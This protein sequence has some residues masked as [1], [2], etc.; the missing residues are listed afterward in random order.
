VA[1]A[2]LHWSDNRSGELHRVA[3]GAICI[4]LFTPQCSF[5]HS[6]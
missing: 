6:V 5:E 4:R 2:S 1:P 3:R